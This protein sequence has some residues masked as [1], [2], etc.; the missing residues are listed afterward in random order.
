MK[1]EMYKCNLCGG[2]EEA[3]NSVAKSSDC[4]EYELSTKEDGDFHLCDQ[5]KDGLSGTFIKTDGRIP[6]KCMGRRK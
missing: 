4:A 3:M 2:I 5:C 1:I 6:S